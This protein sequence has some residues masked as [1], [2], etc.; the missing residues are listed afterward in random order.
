VLPRGV[1][2]G[3]QPK[4]RLPPAQLLR[5]APPRARGPRHDL[6]AAGRFEDS[7]ENRRLRRHNVTV[8]EDEH[9]KI[10]IRY[11]G[12]ELVHHAHPKDTA[13]ITQG[14]IVENKRLGAVLEQI[15]DKQRQRDAERLASRKLTLREKK[16]IRK[17]A[18]R[19]A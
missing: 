13:R 10:T 18:G 9:G 1:S 12:R 14:A 3:P 7:E 8:H 6:H 16:R 5:R 19:L 11:H 4:V 17:E 2:R 15:A